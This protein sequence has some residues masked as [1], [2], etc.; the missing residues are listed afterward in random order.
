MNATDGSVDSDPRA[1][2]P[3]AVVASGSL[4]RETELSSGPNRNK[5]KGKAVVTTE[6]YEDYE[7]HQPPILPHTDEQAKTKRKKHHRRKNKTAQ[8]TLL[9]TT[10]RSS[11]FERVGKQMR[12]P[13]SGH[14]AVEIRGEVFELNR[15]DTWSWTF[16]SGSFTDYTTPFGNPFGDNFTAA[17]ISLLQRLTSVFRL[18]PQAGSFAKID[19]SRYED[20]LKERKQWTTPQFLGTTTMKQSFVKES[21]KLC[22]IH[23]S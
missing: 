4:Q 3:C 7:D 18:R 20:Y 17:Y 1:T 21:S 13:V 14:W 2:L 22:C 12:L 23:S 9:Q 5:G 11:Q 10:L 15:G 6:D 19:V 8:V 16:A